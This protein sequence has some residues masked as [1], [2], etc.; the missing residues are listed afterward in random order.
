MLATGIFPDILKFS[1][2]KSLFKKGTLTEFSNYR[3]V[4][5]LTSFSKII[6]KNVYV[7]LHRYLNVNN[8]L[9]KEQFDFREK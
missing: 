8:I 5:L 7:R 2:V 1:E 4:S 3:P 9:V 6:E